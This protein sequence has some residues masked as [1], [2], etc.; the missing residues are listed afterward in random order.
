MEQLAS[1][2]ISAI[3]LYN[4]N[5]PLAYYNVWASYCH[6]YDGSELYIAL[7]LF[8]ILQSII[9][10]RMQECINTNSCYMAIWP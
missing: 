7:Q 4:I 8:T 2:H 3:R 5:A 6:Q 10:Y 1:Q 9:M